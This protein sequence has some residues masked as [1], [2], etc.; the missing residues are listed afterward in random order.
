M[1]LEEIDKLFKNRLGNLPVPPS[2]DA[3]MRLQA[4]M[5]PPKKE[6]TMWIYYA[7]A[8]VVIL[9]VS[10]LLLFRNYNSDPTLSVAQT[11]VKKP[12]EKNNSEIPATQATSPTEMPST[13]ETAVIAQVEKAAEVDVEKQIVNIRKEAT[14]KKEVVKIAQA[15]PKASGKKTEK[16]LPV[17]MP[18]K[19][20]TE[21]A[22]ALAVQNKVIAPAE[23]QSV[24]ANNAN[25]QVVQVLIKQDNT[26]DATLA[27]NADTDLRESI[28]K[29]GAL[30]KNIYKQARNLKN[31][32]P[33]ELAALG[34]D[35]EKINSEKEN[36]KQKLNKVISL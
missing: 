30:L 1:E 3:W 15:K 36:I 17:T 16:E 35:P 26:D 33:V 4:K 31:G 18:E 24:A 20:E 7:A 2:A 8:S 32:E 27:Y 29:K 14:E 10:G 28:S 6:R 11:E 34:L 19:P 22:P 25:N 21:N 9:L 13:S 23:N 12:A 5:E